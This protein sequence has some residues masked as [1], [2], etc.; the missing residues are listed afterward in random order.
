[1][2]DFDFLKEFGKNLDKEQPHDFADAD[3][4]DMDSRL[5]AQS[6]AEKKRQH[7]RTWTLPLAAAL[8][9]LTMSYALWENM[10]QSAKM[11]TEIEQLKVTL[12]AKNSTI[13]Q[14]D[15]VVQTVNIVK[16]DTVYR[17][18]VLTREIRETK[19]SSSIYLNENTSKITPNKEQKTAFNSNEYALINPQNETLKTE[20]NSQISQVLNI[21]KDAETSNLL[22]EKADLVQNN[23]KNDLL[24][25]EKENITALQN[26]AL[27]KSEWGEKSKKA[28]YKL[29]GL[30]AIKVPIQAIVSI[31][32]KDLPDVNVLTQN[33]PFMA[34]KSS[35]VRKFRPHDF[36]LGIHQG[37][38]VP[39]KENNEFLSSDNQGLNLELKLN[40]RLHLLAGIDF[41]EVD[42]E[43]KS[44]DFD[45][46]Q[47][48]IISPPA[49]NYVLN[50]VQIKQ[51][52]LDYSLG[53]RYDIFNIKKLKPYISLAYVGEQSFEKSLSYNFTNTINGDKKTIKKRNNNNE[54]F[55]SG[56]KFGVG[57]D[58]FVFKRWSLGVEGYYQKQFS[59][60]SS[61]L[62]E[63]VGVNGGIK[64][65]F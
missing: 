26:E 14:R 50:Q 25:Q 44:N 46:F 21:S 15:T 61:F 57:T 34:T 36:V 49:A 51:P 29:L 28:Q 13:L 48:P 12:E 3:W 11:H 20:K 59:Q 42:F 32:K 18:V 22:T 4:T 40:K 63:R 64:Y 19:Q 56:L 8:G 33:T 23:D 39:T 1:M 47:I 16:Y 6:S 2:S 27:T 37:Q 62:K 43:V 41:S 9:F 38:L 35:I 24:T 7:W 60:Q 17:T 45:Q 5:D 30:N 52:I 55:T 58:W 31:E 54:D 10:L 65:H 53:L